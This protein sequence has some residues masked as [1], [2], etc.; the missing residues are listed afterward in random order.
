MLSGRIIRL[1]SNHY[2][3]LDSDQNVYPVLPSGKLRLTGKPLCGDIV[4]IEESSGQ[5]LIKAIQKR[6]NALSRPPIANVD[7]ALITV[8][9]K[10]PDFS[11]Q[12]CDQ[13]IFLVSLQDITPVLAI[14]KVD[15]LDPKD[16]LWDLFYDYQRS[17]YTVLFCEK[18]EKNQELYQILQDKITVLSGQ[19][20]VGKSSL[21]NRIAPDFQL[22]TQQISKALG[23][24]KHTT[25]HVELYPIGSGWVADTP[26]F[27]KLDFTHIDSFDLRDCVP[28]FKAIEGQC[29]F[30]DCLH[31]NEPDCIIKQAVADGRV[32]KVRYQHYLECLKSTQ[33]VKKHGDRRP[34]DS[35][36]G[37]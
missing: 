37:F 32:S 9:A 24:G 27:S 11:S 15:L 13:L 23:R 26:G 7:Q 20:G 31:Q 12:L 6:K 4:D 28:D 16:S 22:Q 5:W 3:V 25:R 33:E 30:R 10:D 35:L 2:Q 14:T 18:D 19:S 29:R 21:I 17:G 36:I 1:I 34:L 8:S